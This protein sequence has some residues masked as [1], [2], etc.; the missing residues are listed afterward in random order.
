MARDYPNTPETAKLGP[1]LD[2]AGLVF[3]AYALL[4]AACSGDGR[5]SY[6]PLPATIRAASAEIAESPDG[7]KP[8]LCWARGPG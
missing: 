8:C 6:D 3:A 1:K 2:V 5:R 7:T 4:L